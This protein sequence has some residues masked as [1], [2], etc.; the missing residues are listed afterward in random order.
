MSDDVNERLYS[1]TIL[2]KYDEVKDYISQGGV[3]PH[4]KN[5]NNYSALHQAALGG[6]V[7]VAH[8]LL[9]HG[10]RLKDKDIKG[11]SPCHWAAAGGHVELMELLIARGAKINDLDGNHDSP[12]HWASAWGG[13][14]AVKL[15][16][17]LGADRNIQNND[18]VSKKPYEVSQNKNTRKVFNEIKEQ[19]QHELMAKAVREGNWTIAALLLEQGTPLDKTLENM[20]EERDDYEEKAEDELVID[21]SQ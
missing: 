3:N 14:E 15:L 17:N 11:M 7:R 1:A 8:L 18:S 10:W 16:L 19:K 12:L 4:W 9:D 21:D 6:S 20:G 2:G 13:S 5:G